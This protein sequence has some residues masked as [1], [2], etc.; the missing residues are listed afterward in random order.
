MKPRFQPDP[1]PKFSSQPEPKLVDPEAYDASEQ[2][3]AASLEQ[4]SSP[5]H[6]RF[7]VQQ[8]PI[9]SEDAEEQTE[10]DQTSDNRPASV[11]TAVPETS[12]DADSESWRHE[13]SAK[14]N[15]YRSRKHPRPPRYPS[16]QLKFESLDVTRESYAPKDDSPLCGAPTNASCPPDHPSQLGASGPATGETTGKLLEF[17]RPVMPPPQSLYELAEPIVDRPRIL[18]VPEALPPP[19][20]LGGILIEPREEPAVARRPGIELP[21][22]TA[23]IGQRLFAGAVDGFLVSVAL[24]LFGYIFIRMTSSLPFGRQ[25]VPLGA[26]LSAAFWAGYQYLLLVC[27]G[28]TPGLRLAK[29][30]LSRFDG[31]AVPGK[32]RRWRVLASILS[33][34]SLGLG[35]AWCFLDEDQLCWHDRITR[36]HLAPRNSK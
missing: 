10:T 20:A 9:P 29:L 30:S 2:Q 35:Y 17:P 19:P 11:E 6:P 22:P 18:E 23:P 7:V 13:V 8:E 21:L 33:G 15:Q 16:L 27:T 32:L 12:G 34:L 3:F 5:S 28:T 14:L 4:K 36:T 24:T 1:D 26:A 25:I 31:T